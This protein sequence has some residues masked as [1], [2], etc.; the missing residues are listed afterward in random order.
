MSHEG[1][2]RT[3]AKDPYMT[4]LAA[5]KQTVAEIAAEQALQKATSR[6]EPYISLYIG[7]LN[8]A[9]FVSTSCVTA[10]LQKILC[11]CHGTSAMLY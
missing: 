7:L 1:R 10:Q 8:E 11:R 9:V 5:K 4:Q 3:L 2:N 6:G